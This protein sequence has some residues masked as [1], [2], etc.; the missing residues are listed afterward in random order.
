MQNK[1]SFATVFRLDG[2]GGADRILLSYREK[3]IE[4]RGT[5]WIHL[6]LGKKGAKEW[7]QSQANI[8]EWGRDGLTAPTRITMPI[9]IRQNQVFLTLRTVNIS[10]GAEP[11][12]MVFLRVFATDKVFVT[13]RVHPAIDFEDVQ[14]L[15]QDKTGPRSSADLLPYIIES[16]L[17]GVAASTQAIEDRVDACEEV[18]VSGCFPK[19]AYRFLSESLRQ[20]IVIRRFIA[21]EREIINTLVR[22]PVNWFSDE[23]VR[24]LKDLFERI[25][26]LIEDIDLLE[27]RIR[28][29]QDAVQ[30][31]ENMKTQ[32]NM[33]ILSIMAGIFL[34]LSFLSGLFGMNLPGIP[35]GEHPNGFLAVCVLMILVGLIFIAVFKKKE[36]I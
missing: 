36:W 32:R 8:P 23:T 27:K 3:G 12:D 9:H 4:P 26:R 19:N 15:F 18:I 21:P 7:V 16:T 33:Y 34:P 17:D 25:Q 11:D 2:R 30:N 13:A 6:N 29:N 31:E 22:H 20:V 1:T 35:L 5:A 14:D 10:P 28:I 24:D